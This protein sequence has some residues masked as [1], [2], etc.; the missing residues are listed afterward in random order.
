MKNRAFTYIE[1]LIAVVMLGMV[2]IPLLSQFYIGFKGNVTSELVTKSVDLAEELIE[3]IR[4][5]QFDEHLYPEEPVAFASLGIDAG[6][7]AN[8]RRTFDDVDDYNNWQKS[9]PQA[10][11]G[12]VLSEFSGFSR[13]VIVDYVNL[14]GPQWVHSDTATYYKR[15]RVFVLHPKI[16]QRVLE[17][18]VSDY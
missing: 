11:D 1:I 17:T 9:P 13:S 8:D 18:I 6:E 4:S 7:D 3:E 16:S 2:L 10:V 12:T 14:S 5:K 15:I